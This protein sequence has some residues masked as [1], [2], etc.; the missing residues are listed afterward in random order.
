MMFRQRA[1]Q[2]A[3]TVAA[4]LTGLLLNEVAKSYTS[5]LCVIFLVVLLFILQLVLVGFLEIYYAFGVTGIFLGSYWITQYSYYGYSIRNHELSL[6]F[7]YSIYL[8]E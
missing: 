4:Q 7:P 3:S 2:E 1:K 6:G 8:P 5:N